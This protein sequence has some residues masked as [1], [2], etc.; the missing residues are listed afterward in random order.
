MPAASEGAGTC[1]I[2]VMHRSASPSR[3]TARRVAT[4]TVVDANVLIGWLDDRDALHDAAV[5]ILTAIDW[6][7][8]HPLTLAEV[9]VHPARHGREGGV[10][11]RLEA[12]GMARLRATTSLR[13]PDCVVLACAMAHGLGVATFDERLRAARS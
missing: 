8:V 7:I 5:E 10:V 2:Q 12:V 13:M 4:L 11:A 6:F 9:L 1:V 3:G